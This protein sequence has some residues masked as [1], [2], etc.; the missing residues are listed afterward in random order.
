[1]AFTDVMNCR[2]LALDLPRFLP[3]FVSWEVVDYM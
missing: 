2:A 3:G 1:M